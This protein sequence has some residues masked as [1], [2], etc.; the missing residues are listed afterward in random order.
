MT[1]TA[2]YQE[3]RDA[4]LAAIATVTD[5]GRIH[6]RPRYGD[7]LTMWNTTIGGK[8][9]VRSWEVRRG[10]TTPQRIQQGH[11]HRY[12]TWQIVGY[13]G[14][15]DSTDDRNPKDSDPD[16]SYH[17]IN[18]LAGEVADALEVARPANVAAGTWTDYDPVAVPEPVV[19]TI[20]GGAL[21]WAV[22]LELYGYTV[23]S[24]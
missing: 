13:V 3:Q 5:V 9:Q 22:T 20:G 17:T 24:P 11:R 6:D 7:A 14:I 19:V 16:A 1:W 18:Q 10:N 23:V 15:E 4:I 21:C 12:T 2:E 8:P